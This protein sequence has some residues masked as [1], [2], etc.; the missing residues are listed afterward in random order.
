MNG[1]RLEYRVKYP[2]L[3]KMLKLLPLLVDE[4]IREQPYVIVATDQIRILMMSRYRIIHA[5][6]EE[7]RHLKTFLSK[8][9]YKP[10]LLNLGLNRINQLQSILIPSLFGPGDNYGNTF[11]LGSFN[12]SRDQYFTT[13]SVGNMTYNMM[14][15]NMP[16]VDEDFVSMP[17]LRTLMRKSSLPGLPSQVIDSQC[18]IPFNWL[19]LITEERAYS[20]VSE[21][22][23]DLFYLDLLRALPKNI[24]PIPLPSSFVLNEDNL[25]GQ[26]TKEWKIVKTDSADSSLQTSWWEFLRIFLNVAEFAEKV[27]IMSGWRYMRYW[28][29][30]SDIHK[31]LPT[32]IWEEFFIVLVGT[33][34]DSINFLP[35]AKRDRVWRRSEGVLHLIE[36]SLLES[37]PT[38][39]AIAL[40]LLQRL[41]PSGVVTITNLQ[42]STPI[43]AIPVP[44]TP[45]SGS[46]P[47]IRSPIFPREQARNIFTYFKKNVWEKVPYKFCKR[48]KAARALEFPFTEDAVEDMLKE[49]LFKF[50]LKSGRVWVDQ[51]DIFFPK[52]TDNVANCIKRTAYYKSFVETLERL[53]KADSQSFVAE[54]MDLFNSL[55]VIPV[56]SPR[57]TTFWTSTK[58]GRMLQ[59]LR[60]RDAGSKGQDSNPTSSKKAKGEK[61]DIQKKAKESN[62]NEEDKE[63][64]EAQFTRNND[65]SKVSP[66]GKRWKRLRQ[67]DGGEP[68]TVST[69]T[70]PKNKKRKLSKRSSNLQTP[71]QYTD[72]SP[73]SRA[74]VLIERNLANEK[75]V[76]LVRQYFA[77]KNLES[78]I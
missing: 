72:L 75:E 22:V 48:E 19:Y 50:V 14:M 25:T 17:Q 68:S 4:F 54:L 8:S 37:R 28:K 5:L 12:N 15:Y 41:N 76:Q 23:L 64:E 33:F 40:P 27:G 59:L 38:N 43:L 42:T 67:R 78:P 53:P 49:G 47:N 20:V 34:A 57:S 62:F 35:Q 11:L 56:R 32:D 30:L 77:K 16:Y 44:T 18:R 52:P 55:E 21:K 66:N 74:E 51:F 29:I 26:L 13:T 10:L 70:V 3:Q 46:Q 6:G 31:A 45:S 58:G 69:T 60:K 61:K 63:V 2:Y 71:V 1:I 73:A 36:K 9:D 65:V 7:A 39:E 24:R